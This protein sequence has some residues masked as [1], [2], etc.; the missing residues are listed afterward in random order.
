LQQS[1]SVMVRQQPQTQLG[2]QRYVTQDVSVVQAPHYAVLSSQSRQHEEH[3]ADLAFANSIAN[4]LSRLNEDEKAV[5]KMNIQR[6]LMDARFGIGACARMIQEHA[7]TEAA[8]VAVSTAAPHDVSAHQQQQQ[9]QHLDGS[10]R[11][12]T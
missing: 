12:L 1:P 11:R 10:S 5:A 9:Q 2:Q 4:H 3:D 7:L 6:I 8:A